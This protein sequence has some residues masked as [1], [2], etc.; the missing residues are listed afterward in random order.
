MPAVSAAARARF[1][2][3]MQ[4]LGSK[5]ERAKGAPIH[6]PSFHCPRPK[7]LEYSAASA[8]YCR[9]P[10]REETGCPS[11]RLYYQTYGHGPKA[12]IMIG[13]LAGYARPPLHPFL[14]SAA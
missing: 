12:V 5:N 3:G 14:P 7:Y 13:P 2:R 11:F 10:R 6:D 4:Q 9:V 8:R 1:R